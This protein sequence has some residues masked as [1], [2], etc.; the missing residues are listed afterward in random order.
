[1]GQSTDP[2]LLLSKVEGVA[3]TDSVP[4]GANNA[5]VIEEDV[6]VTHELMTVGRGNAKAWFGTDQ[7]L[8][9]GKKLSIK[10]AVEAAGSGAAGT[11]P[12]W[13]TLLKASG[14]GENVLAAAHAG[15]ATAGGANSITL[16]GTASAVDNAYRYMLLRITGGT[17]AGQSRFCK[18]YVGATK[19][20]TPYKAF[21]T[22]PDVTS[23]YSIDAQVVYNPQGTS[24][25]NTKYFYYSGKLHKLLMARGSVARSQKAGEKSKFQFV[26]T[27]LYGGIADSGAFPAVTLTGWVDPVIVNFANTAKAEVHGLASFGYDFQADIGNKI[28]YRNVPGV[29]DILFTDR[30][31]TGKIEIEDP[32]IATKDFPALIN[33]NTL[34]DLYTQHGTVAGNIIGDYMPNVSLKDP[35]Y[36]DQD[37]QCTLNLGLVITPTYGVGNDEWLIYTK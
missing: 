16:Q 13:G 21:T 25:S 35:S 33:A 15:T 9:Y 30:E 23:V 8:V 5:I 14:F 27:G 19:V 31:P 18:A 24:T 12:K 2:K 6:Q 7:Q 34:G 32:L 17:G 3:G 36:G 26:F 22:P 11:A 29:E 28:V 37:G 1:M 10:F 20:F 4:D